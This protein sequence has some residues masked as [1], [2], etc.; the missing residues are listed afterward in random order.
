MRK[1]IAAITLTAMIL[2]TASFAVAGP[3]D[4][5]RNQPIVLSAAQL[6]SITAEG[7]GRL[8]LYVGQIVLAT[9]AA[10]GE[11]GSPAKGLAQVFGGIL[12]INIVATIALINNTLYGQ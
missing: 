7:P 1:A 10:A 9:L 8:Q 6:D 5:A 11:P 4:D 3:I 12:A 2:G